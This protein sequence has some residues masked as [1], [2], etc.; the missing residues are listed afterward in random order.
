MVYSKKVEILALWFPDDRKVNTDIFISKKNC[1][2]AK[3]NQKVVAK[4]TKFPQGNKSAEGKIIEDFR[5]SRPSRCRYAY[6]LVKEYDLP[7]EFPEPVIEEAMAI[8]QEIAK[9]G[10]SLSFRLERKRDF[11]H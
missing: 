4:I 5:I 10:Y 3:N 6:L 8:K 11:Y 2:K 7:Y 1:G 9:K